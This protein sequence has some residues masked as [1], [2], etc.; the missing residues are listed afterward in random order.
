[1]SHVTLTKSQYET[2]LAEC[3]KDARFSFVIYQTIHAGVVRGEDK[4]VYHYGPTSRD[5]R[6]WFDHI[7][8]KHASVAA[9]DTAK[10]TG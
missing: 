10:P 5:S 6:T 9:M 4:G 7:M 1:M 2:A 8:I 3:R